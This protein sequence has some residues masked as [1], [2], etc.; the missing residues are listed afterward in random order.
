MLL[1]VLLVLALPAGASAG[2][3]VFSNVL[4]PSKR[5]QVPK[6]PTLARARTRGGRERERGGPSSKRPCCAAVSVG[7]VLW[8][9]WLAAVL[10]AEGSA[11][12]VSW[13]RNAFKSGVD[14]F[15][16]VRALVD[17]P[18]FSVR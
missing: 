3:D 4:H 14:G 7:V 2:P 1:P 8:G 18:A 11:T 5:R 9:V 12:K 15:E 6:P 13:L 17:S 10:T 16:L